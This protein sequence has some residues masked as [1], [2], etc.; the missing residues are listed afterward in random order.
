MI[1]CSKHQL[2]SG[3]GHHNNFSVNTADAA[4]VMRG[5]I[6]KLRQLQTI[7]KTLLCV[8]NTSVVSVHQREYH[9][10]HESGDTNR[11]Y[12]TRLAIT[13]GLTLAGGAAL[14]AYFSDSNELSAETESILQVN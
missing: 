4:A 6:H 11:E 1:S 9:H 13:G 14:A 7:N 10:D 12:L 5:A 3:L 8:R 2:V